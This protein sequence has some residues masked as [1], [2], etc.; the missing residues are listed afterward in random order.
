MGRMRRRPRLRRR[1][2]WTGAI[3]GEATSSQTPEV[4]CWM[5]KAFSNVGVANPGQVDFAAA[6]HGRLDVG[7]RVEERTAGTGSV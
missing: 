2:V 4:D 3:A 7:G 6:D 5:E 1:P